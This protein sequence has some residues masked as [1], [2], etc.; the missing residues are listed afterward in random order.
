MDAFKVAKA[1]TPFTADDKCST[2]QQKDLL[3]YV[4]ELA[5]WV[6]ELIALHNYRQHDFD[7]ALADFSVPTPKDGGRSTHGPT[8]TRE[9]LATILA[10]T[11]K[12]NAAVIVQDAEGATDGA[13]IF[14]KLAKAHGQPDGD[15]AAYLL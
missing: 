4:R 14:C 2:C 8:E 9:D 3:A 13:A 11:V 1:V 12:D 7:I 10:L 6:P 5:T 15:G